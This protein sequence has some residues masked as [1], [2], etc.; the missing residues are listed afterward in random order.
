[1]ADAE[2]EIDKNRIDVYSISIMEDL[3]IHEHLVIPASELQTI[4]ARSGGPGGQNVNKVNTKATL[5]WDLA[6]S[7]VL[8]AGAAARLRALAGSRLS[9]AGLLQITSQVHREQS[10][11]IQ[12]CRDRLRQLV[13]EAIKPPTIRKATKPTKGSQR[14]R[15][16]E[17]KI[18]SDRK[19]GRSS[20][21]DS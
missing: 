2:I 9:D 15:L 11:N 18:T 10:R 5:T 16:N 21:W 4:F 14:R 6:N 8:Y 7:N 12:A 3:I 20:S 19:Q 17:K 1:M 13:L